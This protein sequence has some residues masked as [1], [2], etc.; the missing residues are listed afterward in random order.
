MLASKQS[1]LLML[2]LLAALRLADASLSRGVPW[3]VR[4]RLLQPFL[5]LCAAGAIALALLWSF[6]GFR[7]SATPGAASTV[8]LSGFLAQVGRPGSQDLS[9]AK[10]L[11]WLDTGGL[12]PEAYL[13]GLTDIVG[14][15][16]RYTRVLGVSYDQGQWF[17]YPIAFS[18][19]SS[20]GLLLL[21]PAGVVMLLREP[22]Y[23]RQALFLLLPALGYFAIAMSSK[24]SIGIRHVLQVYPFCILLAGFGLAALWRRGVAWQAALACLLA[25]Q[26]AV[27]VR[28]APDYIPFA[29]AFWGGPAKAYDVLTFD[30]V[31]WGQSLKR[32]REYVARNGIRECWIGGVGDPDLFADL[33]PCKRLPEGRLWRN[34]LGTVGQ[35][36]ERITGALFLGVRMMVPREGET[37]RQFARGHGKMVA[38]AV[39]VCQGT[40]DVAAVAAL[41]DAIAADEAGGAGRRQEAIALANRATSLASG[42]PRTWISLG[43]AL[44][45]DGR[46]EEAREAADRAA[47]ALGAQPDYTYFASRRLEELQRGLVQ[48]P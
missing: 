11:S 33:S 36:P 19:K 46:R 16:V 3:N 34:R 22:R 2:P 18:V 27:A 25:Y 14:T 32:I 21:L 43:D 26:G 42:D 13:M 40:F 39:F 5:E 12:L 7:Y 37:Y 17:F 35:V 9:L 44:L 24:F 1:A 15:S 41:S 4:D 48:P 10:L 29:N 23:R 6:Y 20:V 30:S 45:A 31:E 38:D 28:T 47:L 8:D